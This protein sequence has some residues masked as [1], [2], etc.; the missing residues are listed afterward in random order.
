MKWRIRCAIMA[1]ILG[2]CGGQAATPTPSPTG[3]VQPSGDIITF[4][5]FDDNLAWTWDVY[6]LDNDQAIFRVSE[7]GLEGA[8]VADR[9]YIWSLENI[10]RGD[11]MMSASVRQT[12]GNESAAFGLMCRADNDG[13]GY[14]FVISSA[15]YF[16]LLRADPGVDN[17]VE[18]VKWQKNP[19]LLIGSATSALSLRCMGDKITVYANTFML[20]EVHDSTYASGEIGVILGAVGETAWARF[21]GITL[22]VP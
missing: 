8:V 3:V 4:Y 11:V 20:T 22:S 10:E 9:G 21:D 16:A 6:S 18:L 13:N 2:G 17:P 12:E 7:G 1:L 15:G 19:A 14:A 5:N